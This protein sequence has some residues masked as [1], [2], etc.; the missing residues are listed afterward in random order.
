MS[1]LLLMFIARSVSL[2]IGF[3]LDKVQKGAKSN[4]CVTYYVQCKQWHLILMKGPKQTHKVYLAHEV[5]S[6]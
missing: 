3:C 2:G 4:M 5:D 6:L 1:A